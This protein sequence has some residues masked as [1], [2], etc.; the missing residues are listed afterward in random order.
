MAKKS[1]LGR[2]LGAL[3]DNSRYEKKAVEEAVS[4]GAVAELLIEHIEAN[5]NQPRTEFDKDALQELSDSIKQLG[6]IQPI[7][8]RKLGKDKYQIIHN[9]FLVS[10]TYI[11]K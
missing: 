7:T 2:G 10:H 4:T 5:K 11:Q 8:V 9:L 3:I 1:P 6:I